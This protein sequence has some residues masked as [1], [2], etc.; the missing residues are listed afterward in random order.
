MVAHHF[1]IDVEEYYQVAAF[2]R[3][4]ARSAW[5]DFESR[6]ARQMALL[7]TLLAHVRATCLSAGWRSAT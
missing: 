7:L 5:K 2:E 6:V 3:Y 4:V 1:T